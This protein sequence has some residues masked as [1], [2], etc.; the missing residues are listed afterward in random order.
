VLAA[1]GASIAAGCAGTPLTATVRASPAPGSATPTAFHPTEAEA[2][3]ATPECRGAGTW[4]EFAYRGVAVAQDVPALVYLP[5]CYTAETRRYPT[6]YFLHGKPYTEQQWVDLGLPESVEVAMEEG[7]LPPTILVLARQPE[8]LFSNSDGGQGSYETEFLDGLMASVDGAFRTEAEAQG[9]VVVGLSRGGVWALEIALRHPDRIGAV[10]ALSPALAVNYARQAYD[11]LHL[12]TTAQV[13][14]ERIWLGVGEDD[15]ARLKTEALSASLAA[16]G[17]GP[18]L[19]IVPGDHADP[20]WKALLPA[21][22]DF[23]AQALASP[24]GD[25]GASDLGFT[26]TP[27]AG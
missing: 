9:R 22:T 1:L 15:W 27:A 12:A 5:P 21:V 8:P 13:L 3:S 16:R 17:E 20:T 23:L 19:V 14:P 7:R 11:P 4:T 2:A 25:R 24:P 26:M 6:A 10:A 18:E